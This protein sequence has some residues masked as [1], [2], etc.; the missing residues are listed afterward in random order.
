MIR[1]FLIWGI[2]SLTG[3]FVLAALFVSSPLLLLGLIVNIRAGYPT[4]DLGL[5]LVSAMAAGLFSTLFIWYGFTARILKIREDLKS[6]IV[7]DQSAANNIKSAPTQLSEDTNVHYQWTYNVMYYST[8]VDRYY[9]QLPLIR[10]LAIQYTIMWLVGIVLFSFAIGTP[11]LEFAGWALL[12]GA[13]GVPGLV[14]LTKQGIILKYRLRPSF[15]TDADYIAS[16]TGFTIHQKS[17]NGAYP[18]TTYSRAVR[19]SDG[20]LLLKAGAIRWL[21]DSALKRGTVDESMAIIR[22]HLPIRLLG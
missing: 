19:F 1:K 6:N 4:A 17:L 22:S 7:E 9:K 5:L 10:R 21:P 12:V 8:L 15:G 2:N 13:F 14:F 16:E 20:I 18:W 3:H 11:N